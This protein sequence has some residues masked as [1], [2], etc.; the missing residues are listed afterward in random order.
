MKIFA[1]NGGPRKKHN[2]AQLLQ[3]ALDGAAAA[4]CSEP[5]ETEMIHLYDLAYNGCVSCFA[6]KKIGGKSYGH[7]AVKDD[8][9]PVLEKLSQADG[10]IFGSPIYFGN[11]TGKLRSFFERLMFAYFV[12]DAN[13]SSLA[14]KR[15]PTGFIYTMNV[16]AAEMEQYGYRHNLQGMEMFAGRLFGEPQVLHACNTYQ[17]DDYSKYK[18]ERFSESE[19]AAHRAAQ[20]PNDMEA[21]RRMGESL[22]T[23][24]R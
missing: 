19:K 5:V 9:A 18:C 3:A 10:V 7:C 11:I 4:P 20:F 15:M 13:Y 2:T 8:L 12:Y 23:A 21:A 14:P 17:F 16:T 22:V 24:A 6:C 1:I